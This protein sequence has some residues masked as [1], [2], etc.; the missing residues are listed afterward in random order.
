LWGRNLADEEYYSYG[1][2][3]RSITGAD[4]L[5]RGARRTFGIEASYRF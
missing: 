3:L 5:V 1:L 2:D 4:F